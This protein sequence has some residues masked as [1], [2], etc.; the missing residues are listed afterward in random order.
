[1]PDGPDACL[2]LLPAV[3]NACCGHGDPNEAY[4]VIGGPAADTWGGMFPPIE[5]VLR[6]PIALA[7]F[8]DF[9]V[10]PL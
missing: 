9:G 6:G 8:A 5:I 1:M 7:W 2:G 4:V 3:R 10:G